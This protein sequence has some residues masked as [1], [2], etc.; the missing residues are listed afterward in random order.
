[1]PS[2]YWIKLYH[3]ILD[4]RKM[5]IMPEFLF[6]RCIKLFLLAGDHGQGGMLPPLADI[7]FRL[8][9]PEDEAETMLVDL[10]K[11]GITTQE[12]G[13]WRIT[14][15]NERQGPMSSTERTQRLREKR[16]RQGAKEDGPVDMGL[17]D[18]GGPDAKRKRNGS[19][20][21]LDKDIDTEEIRREEEEEEIRDGDASLSLVIQ[22]WEKAAG[23]ITPMIAEDLAD[24]AHEL[25]EHRAGLP[26][27]SEG[28][29]ASGP[30]WVTAAIDEAARSAHGPINVRFVQAI[31]D[32]WRREGFQAS[33]RSGKSSGRDF[34]DELSEVLGLEVGRGKD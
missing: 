21:R 33:F 13:E 30:E 9:I 32:R 7:A 23:P 11:E 12:S 15:W 28:A 1:M 16:Q 5:M 31:L 29:L 20:H 24:L 19:S 18:A 4:D 34:Q 27:G 22:S 14:K 25:E 3:E 2:N 8:R 26:A 17:G 6:A 10:Q